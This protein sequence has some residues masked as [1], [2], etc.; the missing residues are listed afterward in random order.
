MEFWND[1]DNNRTATEGMRT[2]KDRKRKAKTK[3]KDLSPL[4]SIK[5]NSSL[6]RW[7]RKFYHYNLVFMV[8]NN[9]EK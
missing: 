4:D 9:H 8:S 1:V 5:S 3:E 2:Y 7:Y 6:Y